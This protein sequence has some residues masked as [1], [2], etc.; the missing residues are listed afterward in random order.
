MPG[1]TSGMK[2]LRLI[3]AAA[4]LALSAGIA[5][6]DI[7]PLPDREGRP[8]PRRDAGPEWKPPPPAPEKACGVGMGLVVLGLGIVVAWR[9]SKPRA[10]GRAEGV[11]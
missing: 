9:L 8:A 2:R 6:A 3:A 10:A 4:C 5:R 11:A 7:A 1:Y